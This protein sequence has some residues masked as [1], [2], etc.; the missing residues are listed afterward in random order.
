M[1]RE[2]IRVP[3]PGVTRTGKAS[4]F[5]TLALDVCI[6]MEYTVTIY[7]VFTLQF[8]LCGNGQRLLQSLYLHSVSVLI[9]AV[10]NI[11]PLST[12]ST[13]NSLW[14][15]H[16]RNAYRRARNR[17]SRRKYQSR[18]NVVSAPLRPQDSGPFQPLSQSTARTSPA[19]PPQSELET[20]PSPRPLTPYTVAL[21]DS[22][23]STAFHCD[24]KS[25]SHPPQTPVRTP[26]HLPT[27]V[28]S[29]HQNHDSNFIPNF[30]SHASVMAR[31]W[32]RSNGPQYRKDSPTLPNNNVSNRQTFHQRMAHLSTHAPN[33][34][35]NSYATFLANHSGTSLSSD[36]DT[37]GFHNDSGYASH[38]TTLSTCH[39]AQH[40]STSTNSTTGSCFAPTPHLPT[41]VNAHLP[42]IPRSIKS[43]CDFRHCLRHKQTCLSHA[44]S[45]DP[46][47]QTPSTTAQSTRRRR[48][49]RAEP[50]RRYG[51][52]VWMQIADEYAREA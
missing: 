51:G 37:D 31:C 14:C 40:T 25:S 30:T 23:A 24:I 27:P 8:F 3:H 48:S 5:T 20:D 7:N 45:L 49:A 6:A 1:L 4:P 35:N 22:L 44:P 29:P 9:C 2:G 28:T 15:F 39:Q 42:Q 47:T 32:N 52:D 50:S 26:H 34:A 36:A 11:P 10:R 38:L 18:S 13:M 12:A 21:G 46:L 43:L 17:S 33:E 19:R 41:T 16:L